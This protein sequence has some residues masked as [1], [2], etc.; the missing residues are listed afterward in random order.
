MS[1][2]TDAYPKDMSMQEKVNSCEWVLIW[3]IIK[4]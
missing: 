2:M 4:T 1:F 3:G